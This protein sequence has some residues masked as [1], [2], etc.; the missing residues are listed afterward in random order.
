MGAEVRPRDSVR[1]KPRFGVWWEHRR[2]LLFVRVDGR[3]LLGAGCERQVPGGCDEAFGVEF[4][5]PPCIDRAPDT[6]GATWGEADAVA[7]G[8]DAAA[9]TVDPA[10]AQRLVDG[11]RPRDAGLARALLEVPD[12][13]LG[14]R[15]VV[16]HQPRPELLG[17]G[18]E[19]GVHYLSA[20]VTGPSRSRVAS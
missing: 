6:A 17:R 1:T 15:L 20:V 3:S 8:V 14:C 19:H 16:C 18:E 5:E 4:A 11:L 2:R 10:E 7:L 13:Q 12:D 9:D